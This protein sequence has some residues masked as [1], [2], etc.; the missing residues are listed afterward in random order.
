MELHTT[1]GEQATLVKRF[2]LNA[3]GR[4]PDGHAVRPRQPEDRYTYRLVFDVKGY[5]AAKGVALAGAQ[6]SST[7]WRWTSGW[8]TRTSTTTC[9][10]W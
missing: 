10:C 2:T 4:N 9:R 1:N 3:D 6:L 5:F 8:R 7:A